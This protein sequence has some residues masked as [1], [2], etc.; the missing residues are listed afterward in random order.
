MLSTQGGVGELMRPARSQVHVAADWAAPLRLDDDG[1]PVVKKTDGDQAEVLGQGQG[2]GS[3]VGEISFVGGG[4]GARGAAGQPAHVTSF[5][6]GGVVAVAVLVVVLAAAATAGDGD[7][8]VVFWVQTYLHPTR[9]FR[10]LSADCQDRQ[11]VPSVC[12]F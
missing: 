8:V 7:G 12:V 2:T 6:F 9:V 5:F 1:W 10:G 4:G 3:P 11:V